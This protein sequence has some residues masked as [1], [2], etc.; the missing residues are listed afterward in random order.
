M[1]PSSLSES[2]ELLLP[3]SQRARWQR[4][5]GSRGLYLLTVFPASTSYAFGN[6]PA[7]EILA[8]RP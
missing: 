2:L 4:W 7:I 1:L 8:R 6:D 3:T 5:R